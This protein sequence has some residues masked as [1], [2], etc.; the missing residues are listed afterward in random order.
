MHK[1]ALFKGCTTFVAMETKHGCSWQK[2]ILRN[3][4]LLK[5]C[6]IYISQSPV[7]LNDTT[8]STH[9]DIVRLRC[10]TFNFS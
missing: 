8:Y 2:A 7:H 6:K 9:S 3:K 10:G 5:K 4:N 1:N